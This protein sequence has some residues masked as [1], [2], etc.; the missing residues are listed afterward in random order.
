M[1]VNGVAKAM[2]CPL[3]CIVQKFE[4]FL[5]FFFSAEVKDN[6]EQIRKEMEKI[7]G[8]LDRKERGKKA[9]KGHFELYQ[10]SLRQASYK[11]CHNWWILLASLIFVILER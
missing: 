3:H 5:F 1:S 11:Y 6:L 9:S 2:D 10:S 4:F 8:K 7:M